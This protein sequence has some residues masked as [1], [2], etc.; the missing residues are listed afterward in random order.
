MSRIL[1]KNGLV[2][3][4]ATKMNEQAD[5]Y[6]EDGRVRA[7][8]QRITEEADQ[9]IDASGKWVTPGFIDT[10]VHLRDPGY[11]YKE[12]IK[13]G[14]ASAAAGGFTTVCAMP[15]TKPATDSSETVEYILNK[16]EA[17]GSCHVVPCGAITIGQ[18]GETLA[19]IEA[20]KRSGAGAIS[21]DGRSVL[22]AKLLK[23]AMVIAKEQ[24]MVV[25]SHCEDDSLAEGG[26]MNEGNKSRELGL[27][28]IH[29]DTEDL[30]TARDILLSKSTGAH[31]HLCHVSTAGAVDMIRKAKAEGLNVTAEVCPHHFTL[32]DD[33]IDGTNTNAKMNP[34]LR[35]KEDLTAVLEG[36]KDG[37][38]DC[39][40]TDHAPHTAEEK[41]GGFYKAAN[42]I[43]GF[44]T[45]FGLSVTELVMKGLL[46]PYELVERMSLNPA[47]VLGIDKGDIAIGKV[48][49]IVITDPEAV[50]TVDKNKFLSKGRNT[51]FDGWKLKGL[52]E[53]T[54][55]DGRI[56]YKREV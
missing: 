33:F 1:I 24:G 31:L 41:S 46:T 4:P 2:I 51:P 8:G 35:S 38:L 11:E 15:N 12:D 3:N 26:C 50:W 40:A 49:D 17:E 5:V 42:G 20:M 7:I 16:V 22:S 37:I 25:M 30:I 56:V 18:K 14:T 9:V 29:N 47:K 27:Q 23:D 36:I 32:T 55:M 44:E 45:A 54:I 34:P 13:T 21:E 39:I 52:V 48:A 53:C 10:H 6:I 28:G 43:V 19:P